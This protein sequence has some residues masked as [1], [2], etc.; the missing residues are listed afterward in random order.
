VN[1]IRREE[2]IKQLADFVETNGRLPRLREFGNTKSAGVTYGIWA[3]RTEFG[4]WNS[5]L[6]NV[7]NVVNRH[8]YEI[9]ESVVDEMIEQGIKYKNDTGKYPTFRT[10]NA[11]DGYKW[12]TKTMVKVFGS[13]NNYTE[14]CGFGR[15][16]RGSRGAYRSDEYILELL[17]NAIDAAGT[18]NRDIL[19][20]Y[21]IPSRPTYVGRFGTWKRAIEMCG[22]SI[23]KIEQVA[24][25]TIS[26][27]EHKCDS[28]GE[29]L[30]DNWLHDHNIQHDVHVKY[31]LP[32]SNGST[33]DFVCG[34]IYIEYTA[35]QYNHK[36][37]ADYVFRLQKKRA[38]CRILNV[39][40]VEIDS[41][42]NIDY[43]L[44]NVFLNSAELK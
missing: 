36:I 35:A 43:V 13:W 17:R 26:D 29:S 4:S 1:H 15:F 24:K 8:T 31:N 44:S 21:D 38:W 39:K 32:N 34:N 30:V 5:Y 7:T 14:A 28:Y 9:D 33:C 27:D 18:T 19:D 25:P 2:M 40:L 10:F 20:K 16:N 37:I 41:R 11:V 6:S 42:E 12:A 22:S 23:T 3:I